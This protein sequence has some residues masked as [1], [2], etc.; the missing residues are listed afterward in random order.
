MFGG[1]DSAGSCAE[2]GL[3]G[4]AVS[5]LAASESGIDDDPFAD[6]DGTDLRPCLYYIACDVPAQYVGAVE[7]HS[8]ALD[9]LAGKDVESV[10]RAGPHTH[11]DV[12]RANNW[13]RQVAVLEDVEPSVLRDID[14][15]HAARSSGH[16]RVNPLEWTVRR[17]VHRTVMEDSCQPQGLLYKCT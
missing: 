2:L 8:S 14:C 16:P 6:L 12:V 3:S 1:A 9:A 10:Q 7:C 11:L 13:L 17:L 4:D 5:A 15:L